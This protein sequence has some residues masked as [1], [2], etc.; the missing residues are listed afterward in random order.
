RA[1]IRVILP[2]QTIGATKP[3]IVARAEHGGRVVREIVLTRRPGSDSKALQCFDA[4]TELYG[5]AEE[6]GRPLVVYIGDSSARILLAAHPGMFPNA[7]FAESLCCSAGAAVRGV[8]EASAGLVGDVRDQVEQA[9][10]LEAKRQRQERVTVYTDGSVSSTR[11]GC[12]MGIATT[13]G[14]VDAAADIHAPNVPV[15]A[16]LLAIEMAVSRFPV[17][18][19]TIHADSQ[20]AIALVEQFRKTGGRGA[21]RI[22]DAHTDFMVTA[23]LRRISGHCRGRTVKLSWVRGHA[24]NLYNDAADRA[25]RTVR[26]AYS[27]GIARGAVSKVLSQIRDDVADAPAAA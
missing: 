4:F 17:Q 10:Q 16:E 20:D 7:V 19:L 13:S 2:H 21:R 11:R 9:K 18:R 8:Y 22:G 3:A 25:A 24:G 27:Y 26:R 5:V 15:L 1:A 23:V 14:V 6:L 12:G